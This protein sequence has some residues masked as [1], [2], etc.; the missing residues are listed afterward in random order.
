[1]DRGATRG[2]RKPLCRPVAQPGARTQ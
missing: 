2:C 1:V